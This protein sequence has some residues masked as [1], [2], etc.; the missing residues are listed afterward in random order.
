MRSERLAGASRRW[1]RWGSLVNVI[2]LAS[3]DC[4]H[5]RPRETAN[6]HIRKLR[7]KMLELRWD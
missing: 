6:I 2:M 4:K 3:G 7:R 1:D 5:Q